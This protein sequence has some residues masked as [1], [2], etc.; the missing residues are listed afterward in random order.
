MNIQSIPNVSDFRL[1]QASGEILHR[2]EE[3]GIP[4]QGRCLAG[5]FDG[6]ARI[7]YWNDKEEGLSWFVQEITL[8]TR[9]WN[10]KT[11]ERHTVELTDGPLYLALWGELTDGSAK[12]SV[13][14]EI[15]GKL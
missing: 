9:E 5:R 15:R 13:D 6:T 7:T 11:H 1:L 3:M 12:D 8:D 2:F 10:G 4:A 14:A